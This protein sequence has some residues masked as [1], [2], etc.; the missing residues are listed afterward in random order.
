MV[1]IRLF[2]MKLRLDVY[3]SNATLYISLPYSFLGRLGSPVHFRVFCL[4]L[5]IEGARRSL[6]ALSKGVKG[7]FAQ[8]AKGSNIVP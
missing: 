4:C 2:H 8:S 3:I 7:V 5:F 1:V 6:T